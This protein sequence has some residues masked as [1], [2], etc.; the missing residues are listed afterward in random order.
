MRMQKKEGLSV[1]FPPHFA[2]DITIVSSSSSQVCL[3]IEVEV[4]GGFRKP[5]IN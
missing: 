1:F 5:S 2:Y 4:A 3:D